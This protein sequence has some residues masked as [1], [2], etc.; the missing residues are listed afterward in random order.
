MH[1]AGYSTAESGEARFNA[2]RPKKVLRNTR[3]P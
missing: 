1:V 2:K 3:A